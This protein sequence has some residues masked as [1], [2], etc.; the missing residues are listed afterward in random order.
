VPIL[1]GDGARLATGASRLIEEEGYLHN[2]LQLF[3]P[4]HSNYFLS[5][6][7]DFFVP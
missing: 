4:L 5:Y 7:Y 1:A 3:F 2:S 6:L